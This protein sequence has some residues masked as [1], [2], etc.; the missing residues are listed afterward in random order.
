MAWKGSGVRVPSAPLA[1]SFPTTSPGRDT[2]T[3]EVSCTVPGLADRHDERGNR[4]RR[5]RVRPG[6][7]VDAVVLPVLHLDLDPDHGV[8]G[9]LPQPRHGRLRQGDVG[10]L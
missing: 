6:V 10:D 5:L 7:L 2:G 4:V 9:H 1:S 3:V 8:R